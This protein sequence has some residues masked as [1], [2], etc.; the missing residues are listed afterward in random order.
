[1]EGGSAK[2][3]EIAREGVAVTVRYGRIGSDGQ[4]KTKQ[5]ADEAA[6]LR[7]VDDLI[8]EKTGKGYVEP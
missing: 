3:W 2:F 7:H 4:A 8:R 1:M 5:L 6:A